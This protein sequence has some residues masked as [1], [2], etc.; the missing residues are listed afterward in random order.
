MVILMVVVECSLLS[1]W[2]SRRTR[3][4]ATTVLQEFC[5]NHDVDSAIGNV[6][7]SRVVGA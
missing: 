5:R 3:G 6:G 4:H 7:I 2:R 1:E